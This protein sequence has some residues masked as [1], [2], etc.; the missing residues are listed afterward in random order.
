MADNRERVPARRSLCDAQISLPDCRS[1]APNWPENRNSIINNNF[2]LVNLISASAGG[3]CGAPT[4]LP[5]PTE[6][7]GLKGIAGGGGA[8]ELGP[9]P[10][11][12]AFSRVNSSV[13][14][15]GRLPTVNCNGMAKIIAMKTGP[16]GGQPSRP[17]THCGPVVF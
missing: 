8:A 9:T 14:I 10:A 16:T 6:I 15:P 17:G 3:Q 2:T 12:Q 4:Q 5:G 11:R 13:T 1:D 7:L